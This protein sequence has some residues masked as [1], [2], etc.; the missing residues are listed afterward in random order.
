[1]RL[2]VWLSS[3][4]VTEKRTNVSVRVCLFVL[5]PRWRWL[6]FLSK[7]CQVSRHRR[8]TRSHTPHTVTRYLLLNFLPGNLALACLT[9][10]PRRALRLRINRIEILRSQ[11]PRECKFCMIEEIWCRTR[12]IIRILLLG[13]TTRRSNFSRRYEYAK[14]SIT[15]WSLASLWQIYIL[16]RV[17]LI[18]C[19]CYFFRDRD[20]FKKLFSIISYHEVYE[21]GYLISLRSILRLYVKLCRWNY[22]LLRSAADRS[23]FLWGCET[24]WD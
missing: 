17:P 24:F 13:C 3:C 6:I 7:R 8:T 4:A 21:G 22:K 2:H 23:S 14:R 19:K 1:M 10:S 12:N 18:S 16:R 20:Y 11:R 9:L 15:P 5:D